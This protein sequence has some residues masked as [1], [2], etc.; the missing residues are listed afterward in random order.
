[1]TV[2]EGDLRERELLIRKRALV[3]QHRRKPLINPEFA[4]KV[5]RFAFE[6][7]VE[8]LFDKRVNKEL[9]LYLRKRNYVLNHHLSVEILKKKLKRIG[10]DYSSHDSGDPNLEGEAIKGPYLDLPAPIVFES[11]YVVE[12]YSLEYRIREYVYE[13]Q[14]KE[15]SACIICLYD[16]L[17]IIDWDKMRSLQDKISETFP[18]KIIEFS[19]FTGRKIPHR[20]L[21]SL[22]SEWEMEQWRHG[23]SNFVEFFDSTRM[24]GLNAALSGQ[25]V[26]FLIGAGATMAAGGPSWDS[27]IDLLWLN[28]LRGRD[29][30]PGLTDEEAK[31]E[32]T[33]IITDSPLIRARMLVRLCGPGIY[34]KMRAIV[35]NGINYTSGLPIS[36]ADLIVRSVAQEKLYEVITFN[37][38]NVIEQ[39]L[40]ARGYT[41]VTQYTGD[42]RA[43]QGIHVQHIHG[44]LS[45]YPEPITRG[46]AD[47]VVFSED[48]YHARINDPG[49]WTNRRLMQAFSES[50]C[51]FLGFSMT[52]P[53]VRRLLEA[54][55]RESPGQHHYVF[56]KAPAPAPDNFDLQM[57]RARLMY[58]QEAMMAELGL[59]VIWYVEYADLPMLV[60][61]LLPV[62]FED[63]AV[64]SGVS[65]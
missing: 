40:R 30:M 23:E 53:N 36:I 12:N 39:T 11:K 14:S 42:R 32:I 19:D 18:I 60:D 33:Q 21:A 8:V 1:M 64:P 4:Y 24:E 65:P 26:S 61:Q 22:Y 37:Y 47:S 15:Y 3:T 48:S 2:S 59:N 20:V 5:P 13:A 28:E 55:Q 49:H 35:Y 56:L 51:V 41:T 50:V 7:V 45:P 25:R 52:D 17:N 63:E 38:D 58:L 34:Q 46:M 6:A 54:A 27:L 29:A 44:Y 62:A 43:G 31:I 10:I 16:A 9:A 57:A